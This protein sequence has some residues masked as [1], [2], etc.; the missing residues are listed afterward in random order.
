MVKISLKTR[1]DA[2]K[3]LQ[4]GYSQSAVA[5]D[6][7]I[8]RCSV[9]S[10]W[11]K[12]LTSG[13]VND[14]HRSG[15]PRKSDERN[16]R[17]LIRLSKKNPKATA[18]DLRNEWNMQENIS[19]ATVQRILRKY[20]LFGRIAARKPFLT[21]KHILRRKKWCHNYI[22]LDQSFWD[23]V[24]FSDE[25]RL[26]L[27]PNRRQYVRRPC[28]TKYLERYTSKTVKHGGKSIMLWGAIKSDGTR[29]LIRC[30]PR[31]NSMEYQNVIRSGL[32]PLY[33][34]TNVFQQDGAPCHTSAST[35]TFLEDH[36]ICLLSDW[37]AQS[38]DLNIIEPLWSDLKLQVS[39]KNS[40]NI[41]MLWNNCK[42]EWDAIPTS[43]IKNL[44]QSIPKRLKEV[45]RKKGSNTAY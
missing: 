15:R 33:N 24:I 34:P 31:L 11:K 23:Q 18:A 10:I 21:K 5:R 14:M 38:P 3:S 41:D 44:Y 4:N 39:K 20:G 2:I 12:F 13:H 42:E 16:D 7:Q 27:H 45:I 25:C 8:S 30:P 43:K 37:P 35:I 17:K 26:E 22:K 40:T 36:G 1:E 6:F 32:F 19:V 28:N 9:Q 29:T